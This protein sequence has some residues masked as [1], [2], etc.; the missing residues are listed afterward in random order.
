MSPRSKWWGV[1][2]GVGI[3]RLFKWWALVG[4]ASSASGSTDKNPNRGNA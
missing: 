1:C 4:S 3:E 2:I